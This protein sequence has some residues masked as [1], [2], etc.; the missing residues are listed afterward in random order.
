M[1]KGENL[2]AERRHKKFGKLEMS[3]LGMAGALI[4]AC[5]FIL[6]SLDQRDGLHCRDVGQ[7][8]ARC[9]QPAL[10]PTLHAIWK[11]LLKHR[12]LLD[13]VYPENTTEVLHCF[14]Q[15][16]LLG[17]VTGMSHKLQPNFAG[18]QTSPLQGRMVANTMLCHVLLHPIPYE[19][20]ELFCAIRQV[21]EWAL[22]VF[23][24][25]SFELYRGLEQ[26]VF[27]LTW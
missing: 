8:S 27:Q 15:P 6:E 23:W 10:N 2:A 13:G 19:G 4:A 20:S 17:F 14:L 3:Q 16:F 1:H 24:S 11:T 26:H 12:G 7:P 18:W 5:G 22:Q 9:F 25:Q 21:T